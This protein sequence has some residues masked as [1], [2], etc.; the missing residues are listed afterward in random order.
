M[1]KPVQTILDKINQSIDTTV[2]SMLEKQDLEWKQAVSDEIKFIAEDKK[3]MDEKIDQLSEKLEKICNLGTYIKS[4]QDDTKEKFNALQKDINEIREELANK[5]SYS[6]KYQEL[7]ERIKENEEIMLQHRTRFSKELDEAVILSNENIAKIQEIYSNLQEQIKSINEPCLTST[8]ISSPTENLKRLNL[9]LPKFKGEPKERPIKFLGELKRY[10][11]LVKPINSE[12]KYILGQAFENGAKKW[13][14]LYESE[15]NDF[16]QF[17]NLFLNYYWSDSHQRNAKR[18]LE[19]GQFLSSGKMTKC[20]YALDLL[21]LASEL[22]PDRDEADTISQISMHFDR[23]TRTAIRGMGLKNKQ[24]LL[25]TLSDFDYDE[26]NKYRQNFDRQQKHATNSTISAENSNNN[27]Q[28]LNKDRYQPAKN[29]IG[30]TYPKEQQNGQN[31]N[32]TIN[33][34]A[35]NFSKKTGTKPK[36][37]EKLYPDLS[38]LLWTST[39]SQE[40]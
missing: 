11:T 16:Q 38:Q 26:Q 5:Q 36:S 34:N 40:N 33:V 20:E 6:S 2:I 35:Q 32:K 13:F 25:E 15:I 29:S 31:K 30:K 8:R 39:T 37:Q 12:L 22:N 10:I 17:E 28:Q 7:E 24:N 9:V 23:A 3:E 19:F 14:Q 4:V 27:Q 18:R 21:I 1:A